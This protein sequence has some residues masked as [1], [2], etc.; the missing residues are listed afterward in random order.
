MDNWPA[1]IAIKKAELDRLRPLIGCPM[2]Y[3]S[4]AG[5]EDHAVDFAVQRWAVARATVP[6]R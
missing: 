4:H 1:R 6:A 5:E 3:S 2:L